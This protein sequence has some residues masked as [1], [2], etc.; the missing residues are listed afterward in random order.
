MPKDIEPTP[1]PPPAAEEE[2]VVRMGRPRK[3]K[4][5]MTYK[6]VPMESDYEN[7]TDKYLPFS[8]SIRADR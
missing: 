3:P 7:V 2:Y 5:V 4:P 8:N 1:P 6:K